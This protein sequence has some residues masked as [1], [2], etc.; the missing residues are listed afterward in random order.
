MNGWAS[1]DF[2][3]ENNADFSFIFFYLNERNFHELLFRKNLV[4]IT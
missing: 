4:M 3:R 2:Y 1:F